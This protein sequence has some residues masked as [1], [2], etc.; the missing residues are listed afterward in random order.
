[1]KPA[2]VAVVLGAVA[3][4]LLY[5]NRDTVTLVPISIGLAA[6]LMLTPFPTAD[7]LLALSLI[8]TTPLLWSDRLPNLPLA[9]G[10]VV[11]SLIRVAPMEV[12]FVP[13][14]A[15]FL[16]AAIWTPLVAGAIIAR[17]PEPSVWLRPT[18]L[19][20]LAAAATLLGA[21]VWREPERCQRWLEGIT[22]GLVVVSVSGL[23]VF[24]LQFVWP[25][26]AVAD[27]FADLQGVLRGSSAGEAFRVQNNWLIPGERVTLRAMSPFFPSPNNVGAYL[28][29]A[30]PIAFIQALFNA[31]RRWRV[32]SAASTALAVALAV[33]TFSRST[34]LATGVVAVLIVGLITVGDHA[35]PGWFGI[36]R[37]AVKLTFALSV[38]ALVAVSVGAAAGNTTVL[39]RVRN[40]LGDES[41]TDRLDTNQ[42][43]LELIA[44]NPVSGAGLGNWRAALGDQDDVAYIHNVYLEYSAAVGLL[45]G[46]WALL[47]V[48]VPLIAGVLLIGGSQQRDR[49]LGVAVVAIFAYAAIH[50]MFD[51]NLL[52]PQYAWLLSF[53]LGGSIVAASVRAR[54]LVVA[55]AGIGP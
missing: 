53:T 51:D 54:R 48:A 38:V 24:S 10:V 9:A 45:G 40:P 19:L 52:N 17:W 55:R 20:A 33:L 15:W 41:V 13:A 4:L 12:R 46:L 8:A 32:L 44:A 30:T 39:D 16:L 5:V 3:T 18:A 2:V 42:R 14:K 1:M 35:R 37:A 29:I 50:F 43:A 27:R 11:I 23:V 25:A 31:T 36:R 47:V 22:L 26:L 21:V 49:L 7:R 28:G 34:W 6:A